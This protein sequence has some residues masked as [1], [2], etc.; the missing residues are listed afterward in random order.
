MNPSLLR[1]QDPNWELWDW[2]PLPSPH[3]LNTFSADTCVH[4]ASTQ[5]LRMSLSVKTCLILF[6]IAACYH[7]AS[8]VPIPI[9]KLHAPFDSMLLGSCNLASKVIC[10]RDTDLIHILPYVILVIHLGTRAAII[11]PILQ[12]GNW[13][14]ESLYVSS[15]SS[16][17]RDKTQI[18]TQAICL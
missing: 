15:M 18:I 5:S 12:M 14:I 6:L 7:M 2:S 8:L 13:G 10:I 3:L 16:A 1:P 11:I 17:R 4:L 9:S